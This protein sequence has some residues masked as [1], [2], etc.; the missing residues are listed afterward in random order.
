MSALTFHP[1]VEGAEVP[2]AVAAADV[3][4]AVVEVTVPF[5][6]VPHAL[7]ISVADATATKKKTECNQHIL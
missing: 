5:A 4:V 2:P 6:A 3:R 1:G 7:L